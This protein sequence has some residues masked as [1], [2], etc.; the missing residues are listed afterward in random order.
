MNLLMNDIHV[1]SRVEY[2]KQSRR[3]PNK[4]LLYFFNFP[5]GSIHRSEFQPDE[6]MKYVEKVGNLETSVKGRHSNQTFIELHSDDEFAL[7]LDLK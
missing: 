5:S 2:K 3:N 7:K 6:I 1:Q 4:G